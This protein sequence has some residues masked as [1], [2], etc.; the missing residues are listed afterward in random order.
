LS[1]SF[2]RF[3]VDRRLMFFRCGN[4]VGLLSGR[5]LYSQ[6]LNREMDVS[7]Q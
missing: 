7:M 1:S 4:R 6:R 3:P 2:F 5:H